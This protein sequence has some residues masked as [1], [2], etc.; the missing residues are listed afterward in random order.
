MRDL[1]L[2][3]QDFPFWFMVFLLNPK[4]TALP[5][6]PLEKYAREICYFPRER[7]DTEHNN[8]QKSQYDNA[9]YPAEKGSKLHPVFIKCFYYF[10]RLLDNSSP[11]KSS[12]IRASAT[13]DAAKRCPS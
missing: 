2:P 8:K 7:I 4:G 12:L 6:R 11:K 1:K 5:E 9:V 3:L 13:K 10:H